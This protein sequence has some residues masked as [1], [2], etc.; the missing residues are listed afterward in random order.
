MRNREYLFD[1]YHIGLGR[2]IYAVRKF[3]HFNIIT[4]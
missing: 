2:E 4:S 1:Q 3:I